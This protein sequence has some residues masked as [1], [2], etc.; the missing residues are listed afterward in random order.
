MAFYRPTVII[1]CCNK[2]SQS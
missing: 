1:L 2:P